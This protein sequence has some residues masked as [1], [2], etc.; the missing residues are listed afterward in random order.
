MAFITVKIQA[1]VPLKDQGE[2][3]FAGHAERL[4]V[5]LVVVCGLIAW[6][7]RVSREERFSA[8]LSVDRHA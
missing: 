5:A 1:L 2:A 3:L 6:L 7:G 8:S 4:I